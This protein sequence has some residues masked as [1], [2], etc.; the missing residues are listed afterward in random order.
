MALEF[1]LRFSPVVT[2]GYQRLSDVTNNPKPGFHCNSWQVCA[3]ESTNQSMPQAW[4]GRRLMGRQSVPC[5]KTCLVSVGSIIRTSVQHP[6]LCPL[7]TDGMAMLCLLL[8]ILVYFEF[9][10][11]QYHLGLLFLTKLFLNFLFKLGGVRC[12]YL[13]LIFPS[14]TRNACYFN[15]HFQRNV[16]FELSPGKLLFMVFRTSFLLQS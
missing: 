4:V 15:S 9:L 11:F 2:F 8:G 12:Q 13:Q 10:T 3:T 1:L 14:N 6:H 16:V 5:G 7:D